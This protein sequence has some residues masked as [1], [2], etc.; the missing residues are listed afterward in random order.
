MKRKPLD[1][2][3]IYI[4]HYAAENAMTEARSKRPPIRAKET[5][6]PLVKSLRPDEYEEVAKLGK[7][8]ELIEDTYDQL[9]LLGPSVTYIDTT[10]LLKTIET[11]ELFVKID[12]IFQL[13]TKFPVCL[14]I[15]PCYEG[16]GFDFDSMEII[17]DAN[18][19]SPL[20]LYSYENDPQFR[21]KKKSQID[22]LMYILIIVLEV[23]HKEENLLVEQM[24]FSLVPNKTLDTYIQGT[25]QIPLYEEKI[26]HNDIKF[27]QNI[28]IW[29]LQIMCN[30]RLK[31]G[32]LKKPTASLIVRIGPKEADDIF[33]EEKDALLVNTM[34]ME[35]V[36]KQH[37]FSKDT[38]KEAQSQ[39][40]EVGTII[41][42]DY[43][44]QEVTEMVTNAINALISQPPKTQVNSPSRSP[45][46]T[47]KGRSSIKEG[48]EGQDDDGKTNKSKAKS[49]DG[50]NNEQDGKNT[51]KDQTPKSKN[52]KK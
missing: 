4:D 43:K 15:V 18:K 49:K 20:S 33:V 40:E 19:N 27:M 38:L 34:L 28:S 36:D 14:A 5:G 11:T 2:V 32:K 42:P 22:T 10:S 31:E 21:V 30:K 44:G 13:D 35:G 46:K 50:D 48:E 39:K 16:R 41:P 6:E 23:E 29:E 8:I 37:I 24:Y 47:S 25:F 1:F 3:N 9:L 26:I 17:W 51:E 52:S 12:C 45:S 7:V